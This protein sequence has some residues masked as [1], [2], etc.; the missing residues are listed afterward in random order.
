MFLKTLAAR[1]LIFL[2]PQFVY[3]FPDSVIYEACHIMN[4]EV[5]SNE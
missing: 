5:K 1:L 4:R 3:F 2:P